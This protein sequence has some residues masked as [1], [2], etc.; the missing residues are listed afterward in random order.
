MSPIKAP[1]PL[2]AHGTSLRLYLDALHLARRAGQVIDQSVM[3]PDD[4]HMIRLS[5]SILESELDII[6]RVWDRWEEFHG[7]HGT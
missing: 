6:G 4:A 5:L 2:G 3:Q 1:Q 7:E